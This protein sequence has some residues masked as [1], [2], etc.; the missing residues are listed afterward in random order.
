[1]KIRFKVEFV[2]DWV[3]TKEGTMG[4]NPVNHLRGCIQRIIGANGKMKTLDLGY[5]GCDLVL[6]TEDVSF[7]QFETR[8]WQTLEDELQ[9]GKGCR[10]AIIR[11]ERIMD[12][13]EAEER[14]RA[15]MGATLQKKLDSLLSAQPYKQMLLDTQLIASQVAKLGIQRVFN[16]KAY[17]FSVDEGCGLTTYLDIF[18]NLIASLGLFE[19]S[20]NQR[21]IETVV[22]K[23]DKDPWLQYSSIGKFK[24]KMICIDISQWMQSLDS[25]DFKRFLRRLRMLQKDYIYVFRV[26]YLEGAALDKVYQTVNDAIYTECVPFPQFTYRE[27]FEYVSIPLA[28]YGFTVAPEAKD[29]FNKKVMDEKSYGSFYGLRTMRK[30][31]Y[32]MM[33]RKLLN[34]AKNNVLDMVIRPEDLTGWAE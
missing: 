19:F 31:A 10:E 15:Q 29:E 18:A 2:R 5:T 4:V 16:A 30:I 1:M 26:P 3:V 17:L 8:L 33:H 20:G 9:I 25:P 23:T 22:E 6:L 12:E 21:V 27:Y 28:K 14:K 34:N 32:E 13:E 24:Q 7:E 11:Y